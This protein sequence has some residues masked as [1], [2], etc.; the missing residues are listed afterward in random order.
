APQPPPETKP[1]AL[2]PP[3]PLTF[4]EKENEKRLEPVEKSLGAIKAALGKPDIAGARALCKAIAKDVTAIASE[5]HPRVRAAVDGTR[6]A[7]EC[8]VPS[9][10]LTAAL[11][12]IDKA[13]ATKKTACKDAV[14]YI[15]E[16]KANKYGDDP[17]VAALLARFGAVCAT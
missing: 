5:P 4:V 13:P 16:L 17:A 14:R 10:A 9:A 6:R 11:D 8:D 2:A 12:A 15:D 7:C 1:S 3:P